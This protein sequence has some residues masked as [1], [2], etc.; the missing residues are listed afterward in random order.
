MTQSDPV[1]GSMIMSTQFHFDLKNGQRLRF[2]HQG[3]LDRFVQDPVRSCVPHALA[4]WLIL[5]L[6]SLSLPQK[7]GLRDVASDTTAQEDM[8]SGL[9]PVCGMETSSHGG[10]RVVMQHGEQTVHTCSLNHAHQVLDHVLQYRDAQASTATTASSTSEESTTFCTGTG[11][12]MLNGFSFNVHGPC[13]LLWFPG[14]VLNTPWRYVFGCLL[15]ALGAVFNE[16]LLYLRRVLRKESSSLRKQHTSSLSSA[17]E[18][19]QLLRSTSAGQP[20][21]ATGHCPVWF[22]KLSPEHQHL[23]HCLLHGA[24]IG[25]AYLLMLV[26]MTYDAVL[27]LCVIAG[28]VVGHYIFAERRD[29]VSESDQSSF[30]SSTYM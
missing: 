2:A 5:T 23:L 28:Y 19:T 17:T 13:M 8:P 14:W 6:I 4:L 18:L 10:P 26:S 7:L 29:A 3:T 20:S 16:Y 21:Q 9:C 30:L 27:F 22:R 11:T 25:L 1:S 24:T 15:V 12:T